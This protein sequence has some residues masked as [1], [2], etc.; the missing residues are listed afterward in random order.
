[1]HAFIALLRDSGKSSAVPINRST[2]QPI[3][4]ST[5]QPISRA[6]CDRAGTGAFRQPDAPRPLY[7]LR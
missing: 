2:D 3:N 7:A 1:K 4:R 6:A 5:D